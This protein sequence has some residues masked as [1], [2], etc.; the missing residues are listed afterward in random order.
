MSNDRI[1]S[2]HFLSGKPAW[3]KRT[4]IGYIPSLNLGHNKQSRA[5]A[6]EERWERMTAREL[7]TIETEINSSEGAS[8]VDGFIAVSNMLD[9]SGPV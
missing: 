5:R 6:A 4:Q 3:T 7:Q 2:R 9:A 1:C 8:D